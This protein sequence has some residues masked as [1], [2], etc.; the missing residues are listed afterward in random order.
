MLKELKLWPEPRQRA[1]SSKRSRG[2][3]HVYSTPVV[4]VLSGCTLIRPRHTLGM[5][6]GVVNHLQQHKDRYEG[7]WDQCDTNGTKVDGLTYDAYCKL[8]GKE[9]AY[10]SDVVLRALARTWQVNIVVFPA[11][12]K[13]E[14]EPEA[15]TTQKPKVTPAF[16]LDGKHIDLL[17]PTEGREYPDELLEVRSAP[18]FGFRAGGRS[19]PSVCSKPDTVWSS[20]PAVSANALNRLLSGAPN[21]PR[22]HQ[23]SLS[24]RLCGPRPVHQLR[25]QAAS[26]QPLRDLIER[27]SRATPQLTPMT[28]PRCP[29]ISLLDRFVRMVIL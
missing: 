1:A 8:L 29:I 20:A 17:L 21:N 27:P 10:A 9:D 6:A 7:M 26:P 16:W 5:R 12:S 11:D 18:S 4:P 15:F 13:L 24:H 3:D 23:H 19:A 28:S 14:L 22:L 2:T 25:C